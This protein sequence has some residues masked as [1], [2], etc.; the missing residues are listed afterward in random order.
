M[1]KVVLV[2]GIFAL[3]LILRRLG[4][5]RE[6]YVATLVRYVMIVSLPCL[7]LTTIG[8]LD[9]KHA[10]FDVAVI[11]WLVMIGGGAAAYCAGKAAGY[12]EKRLRAFMLAATFPN[13]AFLGYP[14][15]YSLFGAS[16]LSYAV[17]YDQMGMFP[18]FI[19]LGFFI[20]GGRESLADALRFPPFIAL[21]AALLLNLAGV[22]P[23]GRIAALLAGVGWTT[24]PL[25]IFI[26][27]LKIRLTR[28]GDMKAVLYCLALRMAVVPL[29]LFLALHLLGMEGLPYRAALMESAMPPALTTGI[30]AL[31]Y[32]L[33]E[34]LAVSCIGLGTLLSMAIFACAMAV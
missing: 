19:T 8:S 21:V 26:I 15:A 4:L 6:R 1:D 11:A 25:T 7:T 9:L 5:A 3:A 34:E 2:T 24:L 31:E 22:H 16:G 14:F 20:A 27:G 10:H 18:L 28:G 29:L 33:D 32:G 30:L 23:A 13:T 17:I 12:E